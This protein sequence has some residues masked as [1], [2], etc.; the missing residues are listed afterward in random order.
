MKHLSSLILILIILIFIINPYAQAGSINYKTQISPL[1]ATGLTI[2]AVPGP[3]SQGAAGNGGFAITNTTCTVILQGVNYGTTVVVGASNYYGATIGATT[4]SGTNDSF[5]FSYIL[6]LT[7]FDGNQSVAVNSYSGIFH[8][9][10]CNTG[11]FAST[12]T[13]TTPLSSS[14]WNFSTSSN[15]FSIFYSGYLGPNVNAPA[16]QGNLDLG[17]ITSSP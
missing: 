15:S 1:D 10:A 8:V 12:M 17:F 6:T 14:S 13:L 2:S 11:G 5:S 3:Y 4:S 16:S 7:I 9:I